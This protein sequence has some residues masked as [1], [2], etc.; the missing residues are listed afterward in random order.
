MCVCVEGVAGGCAYNMRV[1][2][3]EL[4]C[5]CVC[6][7]GLAGCCVCMWRAWLEGVCVDGVNAILVIFS[8]TNGWTQQ[9]L[10]VTRRK[11]EREMRI[12]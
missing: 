6:V 5:V 10:C 4:V 1:W 3:A 11:Q 2:R 7:D 12:D 8:I 9:K